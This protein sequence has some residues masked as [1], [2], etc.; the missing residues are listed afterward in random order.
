[1]SG[2]EGWF[3]EPF[4]PVYER[5]A[6]APCPDCECC[7]LPLCA[8]AVRKGHTCWYEAQAGDRDLVSACPCSNALT[9]FLRPAGPDRA[10]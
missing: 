6:G 9:P 7:T 3:P 4:G 5:P 2:A 8:T 1:M 10:Q